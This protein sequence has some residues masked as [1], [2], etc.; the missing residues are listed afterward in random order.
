MSGSDKAFFGFVAAVLALGVLYLVAVY[1]PAYTEARD[2]CATGNG[3]ITKQEDFFRPVV[4]LKVA[5]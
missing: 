1:R 5:P 3:I 4:C 2:R